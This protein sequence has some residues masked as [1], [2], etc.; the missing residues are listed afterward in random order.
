MTTRAIAF[1]TNAMSPFIKAHR[2]RT[3]ARK[4]RN[5]TT[6]K[7][8]VEFRIGLL[9]ILAISM[10]AY[11]WQMNSVSVKGFTIHEIEQR[12]TQLLRENQR[13]ELHAA[14]LQ[15]S[16]NVKQL[17]SSLD[18]TDDGDTVYI[19]VADDATAMR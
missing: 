5:G 10:I 8:S 9:V 6:D 1:T 14:Q 3:F 15:S 13:L 16:E 12:N 11:V 2:S 7:T 17:I 4:K 18:M 19:T